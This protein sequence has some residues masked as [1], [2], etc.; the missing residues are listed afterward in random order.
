MGLRFVFPM[1]FLMKPDDGMDTPY[2]LRPAGEKQGLA[3]SF[4]ACGLTNPYF[5][6]FETNPEIGQEHQFNGIASR[7]NGYVRRNPMGKRIHPTDFVLQVKNKDWPLRSRP[8]ASPIHVFVLLKQNRILD[9]STS[10]IP[11]H[12]TGQCIQFKPNGGISTKISPIKQ[13]PMETCDLH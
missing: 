1:A 12:V 8:A 5:C 10:S 9:K 13:R 3:T 4:S 2:G 11:V 6:C 7:S